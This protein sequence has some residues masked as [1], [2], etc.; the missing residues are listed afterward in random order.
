MYDAKSMRLMRAG[1]VA[2]LAL[3]WCAGLQAADKASVIEPE[4]ESELSARAPYEEVAVIVSLSGKLNHRPFKVKD[5]RQRDTRLFKALKENRKVERESHK[6]FLQGRGAHR[7]RELWTSNSIAVTASADVIKELASR[8]GVE[9]IRLDSILQA[10]AVTYGGAATPE[11]NLNAVAVSDLWALGYNGAGIVVANMDTGVDPNHPDLAGRWRGGSNSWFDPHGEHATPHDFSG[12]GT[13]TMSIMVGGDIGGSAIG[14]APGAAWIAAKL[15]NDA[16]WATYSDIHLAFQWLLDPDGDPA[17]QD[18][19]DVV[20]A[21]WGLVG[22]AGQCIMEFANDIDA[23][24]TAGIAVTFAAGNDGSSPLTSLSPGNNPAGFATGAVEPTLAVASFS[25]RG[26]SACDGTVYPKMAAPGVNI[27]AADLSFGGLP[28][29]AVVSGTSYAAPHAAGTMALLLN[30]F[31]VASVADLESALT[32]SAQDLGV[33][34]ADNSY[35]YGLINALAAYDNLHARLGDPPTITS[36]PTLTA[37]Q[38]LAYAYKVTASDPDGGPLGFTLDKV[39]AGMTIKTTSSYVAWIGWRPN[40]AQV[41]THDVTVRATDPVGFSTTQSYSITVSN[42]NDAPVASNDAYTMIK[43]GTLN[44]AAPGVLANDS[45]PDAGDTL[46]A[47]NY[48]V[49]AT[50]TL[51]GN[52]DGSFSYTPPAAYNGMVNFSYVARDAAGVASK[53]KG[54]VAIA[55]RLNRAPVT[56]D[57]TVATAANTAL[58]IDVLGNDSDPDTA[59]DPTNHIDPATVF[60]PLTGKPNMGGTVVVNADGSINYAPKL[61]FTGTETFMYAVKDTNNPAGASKAAYVRVNVQ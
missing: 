51:I 42:V 25:A 24:K 38:G 48:S 19:P 11:W 37:T 44:V 57:D 40:S 49:P 34:G 35:G 27:N 28:Q 39:P 15:Y 8:V 5:R 46:T 43:G 50:G 4:L 18:A 17:T 61:N 6:T 53:A 54:Y 12:H 52:A 3:V 36:M 13:Q 2:V 20:N 31:P 7:M 55:V 29:Y 14:V 9:S 1:G 41:G 10:P 47:T 33:H 58:L 32:Q 22:S 23:L 45:D 56:V 26:E 30:A 59:I 21:S 60:I 16:G